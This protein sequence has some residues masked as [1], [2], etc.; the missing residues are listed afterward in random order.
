MKCLQEARKNATKLQIKRL[1]R[2]IEDNTT[3]WNVNK[4]FIGC[5]TMIWIGIGRRILSI[6][7]ADLT[8]T[9]KKKLA[10]LAIQRF[11][12]IING[13][14]KFEILR[15]FCITATKAGCETI[16]ISQMETWMESADEELQIEINNYLLEASKSALWK[17]KKDSETLLQLPDS[18]DRIQT[19][20]RFNFDYLNLL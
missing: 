10:R 19:T 2:S 11:T 7:N 18:D 15:R 17:V 8:V 9:E 20:N 3:N 6:E 1:E 13:D 14:N 5:F 16:A 4:L 12:D